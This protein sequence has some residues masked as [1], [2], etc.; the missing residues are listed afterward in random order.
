MTSAD[1]R[2]TA[3]RVM[4]LRYR[5]TCDGC[6][7]PLEARTRAWYDSAR[8]KVRCTTCGPAVRTD[9]PETAAETPSPD[10]A[11]AW[12]SAPPPPPSAGHAGSSALRRYERLSERH[13]RRAEAE[14]AR[15]A[16]WRQKVKTDH[17]VLGRVASAMTPKP[18]ISPEPQHVTAWRTGSHG[19][20]RVG[21]VLDQWA[22][23][24]G[25][26]VL[27]D[28]KVPSS[29]ANID[30]LVVAPSGVWVVDAKEYTGAVTQVD[31]GGWSRTELRL[32]VAGRD[33]TKL[34]EGLAWQMG[35]VREVLAHLPP[36]EAP[37][38]RG[39]LCFVG[40]EWP[41][42]RPKPLVFGDMT[43]VWP[44]GLPEVLSTQRPPV[45]HP[46]GRL[47]HFLATAFPP[48]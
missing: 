34:L 23:G 36:G 9:G 29:K 31:V 28:R 6:G 47:G 40:S 7:A 33:R 37:P 3:P 15:D 30:H 35:R 8:R 20:A 10:M 19:E 27:H 21:T 46:S 2:A 38:V 16:A 44:L 14:V 5:G 12:P 18:T 24:T 48:A 43:V 11:P 32:K 42:L 39:A 25:A 22:A 17:P 4:S 45:G 26:V 1:P 13:L 41:R